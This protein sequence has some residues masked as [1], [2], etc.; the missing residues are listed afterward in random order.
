MPDKLAFIHT[1]PSLIPMFN[2]L[3]RELLP[4]DTET[5]HIVDEILLKVGDPTGA[6]KSAEFGA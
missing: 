2:E 5:M 6:L 1:V 3:S 4:A